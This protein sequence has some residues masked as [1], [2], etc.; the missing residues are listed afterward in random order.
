MNTDLIIVVRNKR[1]IDAKPR[2][3]IQDYIMLVDIIIA[4]RLEVR[5]G[6]T[7]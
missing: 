4:F 1:F 2:S 5:G 3:F 7:W 6:G